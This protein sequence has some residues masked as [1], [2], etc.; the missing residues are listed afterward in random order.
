M[1]E[2]TVTMSID[3]YNRLKSYEENY[4]QAIEQITNNYQ[5]AEKEHEQKYTDKAIELTN[6]VNK[7]LEDRT[8]SIVLL[9]PVKDKRELT[10]SLTQYV[11]AIVPVKEEI[12]QAKWWKRYLK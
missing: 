12:Q 1:N 9:M 5:K 4:K 8:H 10:G 11:Y 6:K 2:V 7:C 3:E